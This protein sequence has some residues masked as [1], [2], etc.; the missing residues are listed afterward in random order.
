MATLKYGDPGYDPY[1]GYDTQHFLQ[2]SL[3][4]DDRSGAGDG[5]PNTPGTNLPLT[6]PPGAPSSGAGATGYNTYYDAHAGQDPLAV[7]AGAYPEFL[8]RPAGPGEAA[9]HYGPGS[10]GYTGGG[11]RGG[12]GEI[13]NSPEAVAYRSR[14]ATATTPTTGGGDTTGG[15]TGGSNLTG[16]LAVSPANPY[17]GGAAASTRAPRLIQRGD[18]WV[19]TEHGNER[20]LQPNEVDD[21]RNYVTQFARQNPTGFIQAG[22][23]GYDPTQATTN[24]GYP[25]ITGQTGTTGTTA[26][27]TSGTGATGYGGVQLAPR[28]GGNSGDWS[29]FNNARAI[30]GG[31]AN[32]IKDAWFRFGQGFNFN[33]AGHSKQEIE[34][35]LTSQIPAAAAYGLH[36]D[37]VRGDQIHVTTAE[38]PEGTWVDVV[39]NAGGTGASPWTWQDQSYL[40][41]GGTGGGGGTT[42]SG[43]G[44]YQA[45]FNSII[46]NR[47]PSYATLQ[48]IEPDLNRAGFKLVRN[49]SG[50][51][52]D[53]Q[54]PTGEIVDVIAGQTGPS[55][56]TSWQWLTGNGGTGGGGGG[57]TTGGGGG[58]GGGGGEDPLTAG[59]GGSALFQQLMAALLQAIQGQ[60]SPTNQ[61]NLQQTLNG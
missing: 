33:P 15:G 52:A 19:L 5:T 41:S 7:L 3:N 2:Q 27:G 45:Q 18:Q 56:G 22:S 40:D 32:S 8:G 26:T 43:G 9:L 6:P 59:L 60:R 35:F 44:Q 53:L 13:Y 38:N 58:A 37:Q 47:A 31:D 55:G 16:A 30:A 39:G 54:L 14:P 1:D 46:G 50:T 34:A 11:L 24:E 61:A 29:G 49:A 20:V 21:A 4:E 25:R 48:A 36:I 10:V 17:T 28:T 23:P 51:G 42:G 57:G 12:V